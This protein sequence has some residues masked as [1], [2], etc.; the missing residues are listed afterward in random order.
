M[1]YILLIEDNQGNADMMIRL[2]ETVGFTVKHFI[3]G[4]EGARQA[5]AERP[6]LILLDFNLP[7]V[8][9]RTLILTLKKRL[10]G[11]DAPPVI[12]VTARTGVV[13]EMVAQSFGCDAF[14]R[15]PFDPQEFVNVVTKFV[16]TE[17][18]QTNI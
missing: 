15:K 3:K 9:G 16:K 13:E 10:G 4:M 8:D 18:G 1:S 5:Y 14:V 6:T 11:A 2:L 7:D 12:A 17:K